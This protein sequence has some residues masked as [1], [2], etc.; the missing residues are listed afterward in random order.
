MRTLGVG[1]DTER[2]HYDLGILVQAPFSYIV[3]VVGVP[4]LSIL[5]LHCLCRPIWW[6]AR[7]SDTCRYLEAWYDHTI[8]TAVHF[9]RER[10]MFF[11][12]QVEPD[13]RSR[14]AVLARSE[15][16][17]SLYGLVFVMMSRD[18]S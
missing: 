17:R 14:S 12:D 15:H 3:F 7:S 10:P 1:R 4:I 5:R 11:H 13:D 9:T 18:S 2:S 8:S 6:L 16:D